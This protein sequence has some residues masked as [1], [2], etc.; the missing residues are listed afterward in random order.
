MNKDLVKQKNN[1]LPNR[2]FREYFAG[3]PFP[4]DTRENLQASMT[5]HLPVMY[6]TRGSF[7]GKLLAR[8]L[9]NSLIH[10]F[11]LESSHSLT[12]IPYN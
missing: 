9:Q 2:M 8:H 11:K 5:L 7:A 12:R 6:S 4:R 3:W 10:S 1:F